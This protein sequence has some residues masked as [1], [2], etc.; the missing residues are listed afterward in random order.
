MF[1]KGD[2]D[3][4]VEYIYTDVGDVNG[5]IIRKGK[6]MKIVRVEGDGRIRVRDHE[7]DFDNGISDVRLCIYDDTYFRLI[8]NKN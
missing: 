3:K 2:L 6:L 8:E 1:Q 4:I 7:Y 5:E